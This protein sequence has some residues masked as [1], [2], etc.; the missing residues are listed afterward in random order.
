MSSKDEQDG[1]D[2]LVVMVDEETGDKCARMVEKKGLGSDGEM[3]WLVRDM[4]EELKSWRHVGGDSGRL[5]LK[6]DGEWSIKALTDALGMYHGGIIIPEVPARGESQSN[7]CCEQAAQ[8]VAE[9][10]RV[11]KEQVEQKAKVKLNLENNMCHW[12]VRWAATMCSKY[13]VGKD[14]KTPHERRKGKKCN[15]VVV[16][17]GERVLYRQ[18]REGKDRRTKFETEDKEGIWLGHNRGTNEALIGTPHGVVRAY[19]FRR[20]DDASRWSTALIS[21]MKG[22]PKQPDP[23]R[24]GI[25]NPIKMQMIGLEHSEAVI[26]RRFRIVTDM[27]AAYGYSA[28]CAGCRNKRSRFTGA[29]DHTDACRRRITEA[30][31]ADNSERGSRFKVCVSRAQVRLGHSKE[32]QDAVVLADEPERVEEDGGSTP[33]LAERSSEEEEAVLDA[34]E[35]NL[36]AGSVV[37][38]VEMYSPPRTTPVARRMGLVAGQALD[39]LTG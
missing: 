39:L 36:E 25:H 28:G 38:V 22:T 30:I 1:N 8:V 21:G 23:S 27:L 5:I 2:P 4:S 17:F 32:S 13:M 35:D 37:D 9:F 19:S 3:E 7:G 26:P 16:P 10:I 31:R 18:I 11:L 34:L 29:R 6:S 24:P 12:M 14:G 20:R 33:V 15:L